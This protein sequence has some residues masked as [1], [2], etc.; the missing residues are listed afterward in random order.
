MGA[1]GNRWRGGWREVDGGWW[2]VDG[3]WGTPLRHDKPAR[4]A[5]LSV[6]PSC[7]I[8]RTQ[9]FRGCDPPGVIAHPSQNSC[10][11]EPAKNLK[12]FVCPAELPLRGRAPAPPRTRGGERQKSEV[13]PPRLRPLGCLA[14]SARKLRMTGVFGPLPRGMGAAPSPTICARWCVSPSARVLAWRSGVRHP[15]RRGAAP[16]VAAA[17]CRRA[18][19]ER[20]GYIAGRGGY[21]GGRLRR[22]FL[23]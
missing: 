19:A 15:P 23:L 6:R 12:L 14:D 18:P 13:L 7:R 1:P 21:I 5:H 2:I 22:G 3:G 16:D 4:S 9:C 17:L 10:H 20:G 11:S 8:N